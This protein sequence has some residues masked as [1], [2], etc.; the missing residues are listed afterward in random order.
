MRSVEGLM[1]L[2]TQRFDLIYVDGSHH[3]LDCF[4]DLTLAWPL[5][6][7]GGCMII[8]DYL[9]DAELQCTIDLFLS[10]LIAREPIEILFKN[11]RIGLRR[12]A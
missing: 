8:D 10:R 1:A 5:V 4:T 12:A 11:Y 6:Q 9:F 7:H 3:P 2:Q